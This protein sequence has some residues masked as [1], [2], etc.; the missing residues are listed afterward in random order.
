MVKFIFVL[1]CVA[2]CELSHPSHRINS[3][4]DT[5]ERCQ[6]PKEDL[7]AM[8]RSL[9]SCERVIF[10]DDGREAFLACGGDRRF[11][12]LQPADFLRRILKSRQK[13]RWPATGLTSAPEQ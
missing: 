3:A 6:K 10:E 7:E 8:S 11:P 9:Y 4:Y 13:Y 5:I 1:Y 12:A 2:G